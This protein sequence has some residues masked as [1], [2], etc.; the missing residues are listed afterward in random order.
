[1]LRATPGRRRMSPSRSSV[2]TIWC[3]DGGL[4]PK[5]R[6]MSLSAGER[7]LVGHAVCRARCDESAR[8]SLVRSLCVFWMRPRRS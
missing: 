2:S 8:G 4:T 7:P 6:W 3:T 5:R 1:M